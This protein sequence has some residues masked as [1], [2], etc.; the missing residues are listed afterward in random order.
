MSNENQNLL[1]GVQCV[2]I[3]ARGHTLAYTKF[4]CDPKRV[5]DNV[6]SVYIK[7]TKK[8]KTRKSSSNV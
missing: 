3:P 7:G 4:S 1:L 2:P 5:R 6:M 8:P